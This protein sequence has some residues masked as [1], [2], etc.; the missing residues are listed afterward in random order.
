M[1]STFGQ[2]QKVYGLL[3]DETS[4]DIYLNRLNWMI[5]HDMRYIE[6]VVSAY[7]PGVP[8][9]TGKTPADLRELMPD[10]RK[11]VLYGA[12]IAGKIVLPYW[13]DDERFIGFC[14]Q[15]EEKQK[16]GYCGWPV[17]SPEELLS[18]KDLS[19]VVSTT[20]ADRE[21]KRILE[22]G[23]YPREQVY[24]LIEY[25]KYEDPGQYF[26]PDFISYGREEVLIDAGCLNLASSLEFKKYCKSVKK[27]YAFEPDPE[28][29]QICLERKDRESLSEVELLPYGTW[30]E[31]TTLHFTAS[32]DGA[33]HVCKAGGSS[34]PVVPIDEVIP[35][36]ERVTMIKMDIEGSELESLK[37]AERVIRRDKP[38]LAVCIYH[39][40]EDM[41]AIPLYIKQ[42]VPDYKLYIRHH[43]N[44]GNETGSLRH[45][46]VGWKRRAAERQ[47]PGL[48]DWEAL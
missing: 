19:V 41:T 3:E 12:G 6:A 7:L 10:D 8:H 38:K 48:E 42:L 30:S 4:R 29:Y 5:S 46:A 9:F 27:I 18:R 21:I 14:S 26:S 39:K 33:S 45:H 11:I 34:I 17:M 37:G 20:M 24:S 36:E 31:R 44:Y 15:T 22:E 47:V 25:Y 32:A 40:P 13:Q 23:G 43:S 35:E 28:C 1:E 2:Y 16:N